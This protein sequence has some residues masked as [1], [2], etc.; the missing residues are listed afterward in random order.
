MYMIKVKNLSF[1]PV[2][3]LSHTGEQLV[4]LDCKPERSAHFTLTILDGDR[5][6]IP[7]RDIALKG[8][9]GYVRMMLPPPTSDF[10]AAVILTDRTGCEAARTEVLWRV[11]REWTIYVML[12]SHTDIGLHNSQYHQRYYSEVFLDAAMKLCDETADRPEQDQYR[13]V[14]E[15]TWF[16][17]NYAADRGEEAARNVVENYIKPGRIGLC[18]GCAGNHTQCYGLEQL[19]RSAYERS[20]QE[21]K[22]GI[23]THTMTMIDNN[24]ISW[25]LVQA[26]SNAGFRNIIFAPNQWNPLPSTVYYRDTR[27]QSYTWNPGAGGGGARVD[28]RYDSDIPMVFWWQ[29]Q[30]DDPDSR[31]LVCASTQY[32]HGA[33]PFG[34]NPNSKANTAS[35]ESMENAVPARITDIEEKVPYDVWLIANYH[36]DQHPS[37]DVTDLLA[38]WNAKWAFPKFRTLGN[39]D[40]PFDILRNRFSDVIP[41]LRGEMTGGWYQHPLS[42]PIILAKKHEAD[43]LLPTAEKFSTLAALYDSDYAYPTEAFRRAWDSLIFNDEH[44]YGTSG[45]QGRRVYE[46]WM[47]HRDWVD[48]A[49]NTAETELNRALDA[50]TS[51]IAASEPS[52]VLFNPTGRQRTEFIAGKAVDI[53]PFGYTSVPVPAPDEPVPLSFDGL[54]VI[55]NAFYRLTFAENGSVAS[56]FDKIAGHEL[57][58]GRNLAE[59]IYTEDN[60]KNFVRPGSAIFAAYKSTDG[61]TVV[62]TADEPV[63]GARV[64][65]T[66]FLPEHERRIDLE[67]KLDHVRAMINNNRY[68]RYCYCGFPFK[69]VNCRRYCR[70]NGAVAEYAV[71]LTGHGTDTYMESSEWC[72]AEMDDYGIGLL[73]SDSELVEF[74]RIHHDKTDYGDAGEG[75]AIYAYLANDWL[76]MHSIGGSHENYRFRFAIT[77]YEGN[78]RS[79]KLAKTAELWCNPVIRRDIPAQNGSLPQTYSFAEFD[80]DAR[81]VALKPAEDG[82]GVIV[83]LCGDSRGASVGILGE[84]ADEWNDIV[85]RS[86]TKG[87]VSDGFSTLRAGRGIFKTKTQSIYDII[88]SDGVPAPIGSV[89]TGLITEP[90]AARGEENGMLYLLWGQNIEP[91]LGGYELYRSTSPDFIC[92]EGTHIADVEPGIFRVGRY[93]DRGLENHTEYFYRVR[94]V[95]LSGVRGPLS[96]VFSGITREPIE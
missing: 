5:E 33:I 59:F 92:N 96:G 57:S 86:T 76:Q 39:P 16:W 68:Y 15:G 26:Y 65:L 32:G 82:D 23:S 14:M 56:I 35:L 28:V 4:I 91:D 41:T 2:S 63:S 11:P 40:E 13:Y 81:F 20:R 60:H 67:L 47:Q 42:A 1:T 78:H 53:P 19:C 89:Y 43:R 7:P 69:L 37:R 29:G 30:D 38:M 88:G 66:V 10:N 87:G 3:M 62:T 21:E 9:D 94:A 6:Y 80:T 34:F 50:L 46:T 25:P 74:D 27:H 84:P 95:S 79:A 55:E 8:G 70:L 48:K 24:G 49:H 45:Y 51:R 77:T 83:R 61:I 75:S 85:E 90:K 44:S 17:N 73:Q 71:D 31:L 52:T 58:D 18:G 22:W 64:M 72:C 93:I 54:L 36:D 12:S